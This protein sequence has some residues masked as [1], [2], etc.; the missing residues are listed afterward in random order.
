MLAGYEQIY[1]ALDKP[2]LAL[3]Y[4]ERA[5]AINPN[6][7]SVQAAVDELKRLIIDKRKG[8]I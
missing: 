6:L 7:L 2:E 3:T 4:F 1:L 8:T 5:L